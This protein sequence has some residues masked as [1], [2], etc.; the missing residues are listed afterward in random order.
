MKNKKLDK[1][2][3]VRCEEYHD[4]QDGTHMFIIYFH[5]TSGKVELIRKSSIKPKFIRQVSKVY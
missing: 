5:H 3:E 4:H 1:I 2:G